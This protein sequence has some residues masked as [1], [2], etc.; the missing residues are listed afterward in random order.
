MRGAA[1][2]VEAA[3]HDAFWNALAISYGTSGKILEF[4]RILTGAPPP[5]DDQQ[6]TR[7]RGPRRPHHTE[8]LPPDWLINPEE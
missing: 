2:A 6:P 5:E 3:R 7:R 4:E 1:L 8:E